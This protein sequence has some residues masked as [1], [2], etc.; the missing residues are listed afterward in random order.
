M[1]GMIGEKYETKKLREE[2]ASFLEQRD[3][4]GAKNCFLDCYQKRPDVL[5]EASDVSG[6]LRL[7]MQI[8]STCSFEDETYHSCIL[9]NIRSYDSLICHFHH[10]NLAVS[11]I[12]SDQP[13]K[14]DLQFLEQNLCITPI[15]VE[16]AVQLFCKNPS[17]LQEAVKKVSSY[18]RYS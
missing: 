11:H 1:V 12:L 14:Y 16:I 15:A 6:E 8:I 10:F 4:E 2:L 18:C 17:I 9:D 3:Y 7:C 5:M 13:T